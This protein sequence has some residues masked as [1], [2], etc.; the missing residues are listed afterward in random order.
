MEAT[1]LIWMD[2]KFV[3]WEDA[4][5]H[6]L[7]HSLHYGSAVF[8]GI[9]VYDTPKGP[10]V[11]KLKEHMERLFN[12]AKIINMEV[13]NTPQEFVKITKELLQ[14][15]DLRD[16]YIRPLLYYGY[17]KMGLDSKG[18]IAQASIA[19]WPWGAY[20]GEEGKLNGIKTKIS[21][22]SRHFPVA[23]LNHAKV[24]GFYANS[25]LAKMDAIKEGYDEA[26]MPDLEGNISECTG[27]NLFIV[28]NKEIITPTTDNVLVGITRSSIIQILKDNGYVVREEKITKEDLFNADECFMSGTAAEITPVVSV[29]N[30]N[31]NDG[32]VGE[33]TKFVQQ[34][35]E[36]IIHGKDEKYFEWLDFVNE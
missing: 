29:D 20:L 31:I 2:G 19:A 3:P 5:V 24:S 9:R 6:V 13:K 10:A 12:S 21:P 14:K 23:N 22:Y 8:E 28:K 33:I 18:L 4:K 16:G 27:E 26:I 1:K 32:K 36:E 35:Y 17:G 25:T 34:K 7:T 11:F 15:I 30:K